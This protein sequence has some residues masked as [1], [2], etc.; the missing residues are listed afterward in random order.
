M[1]LSGAIDLGIGPQA[2]D[3]SRRSAERHGPILALAWALAAIAAVPA[4][5][6]WSAPTPLAALSSGYIP[7]LF[8]Y[9]IAAL[10]CYGIYRYEATRLDESRAALLVFTVFLLTTMVNNVHHYNIDQTSSYFVSITNDAWQR[11]NHDL[12][13]QLSPKVL[14]HSYRFLPDSI[15]RWMELARIDYAAARDFYRLIV[16][17]I[18]FY[19]IYRYARLYCSYSGA[20]LAML[21]IA[22]TYPISFEYYAGQ[23]TDPLSHLSFVLAF[24][25]LETGEFAALLT[26]LL[27]G[28]FTK[29]TVLAMAGYYILFHSKE[30]GYRWKAPVLG[31]SSIAVFLG[32]RMFVLHGAP[33]YQEISQTNMIEQLRLNLFDPS[34][35]APFALTACA[36]L[37]VLALAWKTTPLALKRQVLYLLP[38]L[39]ISSLFFSWLKESRNFMPMVFALAVVAGRY[40]TSLALDVET[41][42][43]AE[44]TVARSL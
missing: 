35:R 4:L 26:V 15:V 34:W 5:L 39:F 29:E 42:A 25:F 9:L 7:F 2:R 1:Q 43:Q 3:L 36:L 40:A 13:I 17:L 32:V 38:V 22:V 41:A 24:I 33:N 11:A 23:L 31:L 14:P 37:P 30:R 12:V 27:I 18:L 20:L 21:L 19:T 8:D 16:G 44:T 10:V 6:R 28:S